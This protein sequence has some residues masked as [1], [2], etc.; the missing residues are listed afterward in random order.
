[1]NHVLGNT[2]AIKQFYKSILSFHAGFLTH[3]VREIIP[4]LLLEREY[5]QELP[6]SEPIEI[7]H[8]THSHAIWVISISEDPAPKI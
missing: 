8:Y 6:F 3:Y 4:I 2:I 7:T 1:M 5:F